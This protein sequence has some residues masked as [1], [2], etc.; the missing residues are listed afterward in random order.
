MNRTS[1]YAPICALMAIV[2]LFGSGRATA[3]T[4][5]ANP[6]LLHQFCDPFHFSCIGEDA[7]LG[8][9]A[10]NVIAGSDGAY[11]GTTVYNNAED[12]GGAIYRADPVANTVVAIYQF[13]T[14]LYPTGWLKTDPDGNLYGGYD[15]TAN[16]RSEGFYRLSPT[17][18]FTV[19]Y[20]ESKSRG[21]SCNAPVR[22]SLGNWVGVTS[23]H[24]DPFVYKLSP[25][26]VFKVLHTFA[27]GLSFACPN[28]QPVLAADGNLYGVARGEGGKQNRSQIFRI[29]PDD[30]FT[31][32]HE[33]DGAGD[34]IAMTPLTVGPDGALYG[35]SAPFDGA[36]SGMLYRLS[37]D[38]QFTYVASLSRGFIA[39]PKLT[40]MPDGYFYGLGVIDQQS[41][42]W[43]IFRLSP[44][45]AFTFLDVPP[46]AEAYSQLIRGFDNAL[47]GTS[48]DGGQERGGT[49]Y[50]YVPP[51]VQ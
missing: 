36:K 11:Y 5:P 9:V 4:P 19:I 30:T 49:L 32:V 39:G 48:Y 6:Q 1:K 33:F 3:D 23:S 44:A 34:I 8:H 14:G 13:P 51:P 37:L 46:A 21:F 47:Y 50:R 45:G 27:F 41:Q 17:G 38:G 28:F 25:S 42:S 16:G 7:A 22:D 12:G 31:V 20:D 10:Q 2:A 40:L 35:I 24:R 18:E 15:Q 43:I 26:G 29:A